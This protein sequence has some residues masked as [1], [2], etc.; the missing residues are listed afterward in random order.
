MR[1]ARRWCTSYTDYPPGTPPN[2]THTQ[3]TLPPYKV[4]EG[5]LAEGSYRGA[6][7]GLIERY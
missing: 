2:L 3:G 7:G 1:E 5:D 4:L 6:G